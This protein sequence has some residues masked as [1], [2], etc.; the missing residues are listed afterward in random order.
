MSV[1]ASFQQPNWN[2]FSGWSSSRHTF[3]RLESPGS[4]I[5]QKHISS[6]WLSSVIASSNSIHT[7]S[8]SLMPSSYGNMDWMITTPPP[9][10]LNLRNARAAGI[11]IQQWQFQWT[12]ANRGIHYVYIQDAGIWGLGAQP[13][14]IIASRNSIHTSSHFLALSSYGY[15]NWTIT[16][17]PPEILYLR[18]ARAAG[19]SLS[20]GAS[21]GWLPTTVITNIVYNTQVNSFICGILG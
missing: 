1:L 15:M 12:R 6:T 11:F 4:Y 3:I 19:I 5:E 14:S 2:I 9:E 7:S 8:H 17:A 16:T 20:S 13:S 10:I 21:S 18:K